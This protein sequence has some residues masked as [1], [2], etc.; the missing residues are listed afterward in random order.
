MCVSFLS[1]HICLCPGH[2]TTN[3]LYKS[4]QYCNKGCKTYQ[5][6]GYSHMQIMAL[7][8]F[9]KAEVPTSEQY[10]CYA[11]AKVN[12]GFGLLEWTGAIVSQG[13]IVKSKPLLDE[14]PQSFIT[15][16]VCLRSLIVCLKLTVLK[17]SF[18]LPAAMKLSSV[19]LISKRWSDRPVNTAKANSVDLGLRKIPNFNGFESMV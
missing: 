4:V 2:I 8:S 17:G 18:P 3:I 11:G 7:G 10:A 9:L 14:S 5:T 13:V 15:L 16:I 12:K 1:R 6:C 19:K